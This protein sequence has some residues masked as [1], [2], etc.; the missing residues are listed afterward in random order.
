MKN[1][2]IIILALVLII[3]GYFVFVFLQPPQEQVKPP[4][5]QKPA[6]EANIKVFNPKEGE[7]VGL[8]LKVKGEARVFEDTVNIRLKEKTG[9][10]LVEDIT[11][12]QSQEIGQFGPF[13]K[14]LSYPLPKTNEGVL[15]VF[16]ISAKDGSE[17]DKV[18]IPIKF[19]EV[20]FLTIKVFFG[21]T[22]DYLQFFYCEKVSPIDR[23]IQKT[24]AVAKAALTE[25]L[26]G[27]TITEEKQGFITNLNSGVKINSL[28]V[29]NGVAKLD[30]NEQLEYQVGGSCR[31]VAIQAQITETLK[32]FPTVDNVIISI[33]GRTED[34]LQ[35]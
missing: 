8:P 7:E 15:E 6:L 27:P 26:K 31:V 29:E 4:E 33:N 30:F 28:T 24:Q 13:E 2:F 25:L 17:I 16:Q 9:E 18:I 22:K 11:M 10:I 23:R 19:K 3:A 14:E 5:R 35:P 20:E 12:T 32:Q 21:N 34:I 1:N